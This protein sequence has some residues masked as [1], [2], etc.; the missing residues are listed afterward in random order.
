MHS[1][2]GCAPRTVFCWKIG[3]S[4]ERVES[5]SIDPKE[6]VS[7]GMEI[8]VAVKSTRLGNCGSLDEN[9]CEAIHNC[10]RD[11]P[12]QWV[13]RMHQ[14]PHEVWGASAKLVGDLGRQSLVA[15]R[16]KIQRAQRRLQGELLPFL[17]LD[18][19]R[20]REIQR[21]RLSLLLDPLP[22]PA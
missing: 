13:W 16:H 6:L 11:A 20:R 1:N 7:T 17:L 14:V 15:A 18:K 4:R 10:G 12:R 2:S 8:M 22:V 5:V 21:W 3:Q 19:S 9:S